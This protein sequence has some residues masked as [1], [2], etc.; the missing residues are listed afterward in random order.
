L[1]FKEGN[2]Q[3]TGYSVDVMQHLYSITGDVVET[4]VLP[5]ARAYN[6]ALSRPNTLIYSITRSKL[7]EDKF[8]WGG[9][10][11]NE[12]LHVWALSGQNVKPLTQLT[13]INEFEIVLLRQSNAAQYLSSKGVNSI[14][15]AMKTDLPLPLLY[16][17]RVKFVI[18]SR[19]PLIRRV[20]S[21]GFDSDKLMSVFK[22]NEEKFTMYFAF[23]V[24]T[25]PKIVKRFQAAYQT[26]VNTGALD[27]LKS[28]WEIK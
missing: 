21:M 22:L 13:D 18:G 19:L 25:E 24:G 16:S 8:I 27:K 14:Y 17:K 28:K 11:R 9:P 7:R 26:L 3:L 12:H 6:M 20:K 2:G 5:W 10:L 1:Q 4:S 23:S 15:Y